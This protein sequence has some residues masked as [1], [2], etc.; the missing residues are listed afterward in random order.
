MASQDFLCS[1]SKSWL[2]RYEE[3]EDKSYPI[4]VEDVVEPYRQ[5][6]TSTPYRPQIGDSNDQKGVRFSTNADSKQSFDLDENRRSR[7]PIH[8]GAYRTLE[9]LEVNNITETGRKSPYRGGKEPIE[10]IVQRYTPKLN[11][12]PNDTLDNTNK[13]VPPPPLGSQ[14]TYSP[15][16]GPIQDEIHTQPYY[17]PLVNTIRTNFNEPDPA[18]QRGS[19]KAAAIIGKVYN[20]VS[21]ERIEELSS[22]YR[23]R[24]SRRFNIQTKNHHRS[25]SD[26][27]VCDLDESSRSK[28]RKVD[29][30][31][32]RKYE[33][34]VL[35][36]EKLEGQ[37]KCLKMEVNSLSASKKQA[38]MRVSRF[39]S[40]L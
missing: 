10:D 28:G 3:L 19:G 12:Y 40:C 18:L 29:D 20:K 14:M 38:E 25:K 8:G 32:L 31:M 1:P 21:D 13:V 37:I 23:E 4:V 26:N 6:L 36:I 35:Q 27:A 39:I 2:E 22:K 7:S 30:R 5:P 34:A 15:Y 16:R 33:N 24:M 9:D 17:G 11:E